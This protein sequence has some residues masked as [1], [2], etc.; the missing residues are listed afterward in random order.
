M[1]ISNSRPDQCVYDVEYV[2]VLLICF[3]TLLCFDYFS[4]LPDGFFYLPVSTLIQSVHCQ[5]SFSPE[6]S[7]FQ[8]PMQIHFR[9]CQGRLSSF[10]QAGICKTG[11]L[12]TTWKGEKRHTWVLQ[13]HKMNGLSYT[14]TYK[15]GCNCYS[16]WHVRYEISTIKWLFFFTKTANLGKKNTKCTKINM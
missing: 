8:S 3:F 11:H 1:A 9:V 15:Q 7:L 4:H 14:Y 2:L 10:S 16:K 5:A 6:A 12:C 13:I